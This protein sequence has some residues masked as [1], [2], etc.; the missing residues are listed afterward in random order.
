[1]LKGTHIVIGVTGGIAA[2]KI[3]LLVRD[4]KRS[5]ADVRVVMSESAA[6]FVTPMTLATVSG[7]DVVVGTFPAKEKGS[8]RGGTWHIDLGRW[9]GVMLI[10][11]ATANVIAKLANG[12]ADNA[13]ET[14]ALALRCPLIVAPSMDVDMWQ[15][16]STQ[17]NILALK[18]L[19]YRVLPPDEGEL[20]SGLTGPGRLPEIA[21]LIKALEE[22][23]AR[24]RDDL[25]GKRVLVT[26]GPT[27]EP[28]DPVRFIGNRSSGK[29]G[30][31]IANA[32]AQRGATV[33]LIAGNVEH[34]TPRNV[35]RIDVSSASDMYDAVMANRRK[36][37][38]IIMAAAVADYAPINPSS[39]K[40]KKKI[41][42]KNVGATRD[43]NAGATRMT[44]E[45]AETKDIL[46]ELGE[47]NAGSVLVGFALETHDGVRH[48]KEK[49]RAKKLDFIV[50]NNPL[51]K[52]AG[53]GTDTNIVT[54]IS[55][56]G[57]VERLSKMSKF[58][59]AH[60]LLDRAAARL[61]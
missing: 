40:I 21:V 42:D 61:K 11:P 27:Y 26:A 22:T 8:A 28:I 13:V 52:G 16:P 47:K 43:K 3:P 4:L 41:T 36:Q 7:N 29:M 15:H 30:F 39:K 32:A 38:L 34:R 48:A 44:L 53:F 51:E 24:T 2:Y 19:G 31:A 37:D 25:K 60:E 9:A 6:E 12:T 57:K 46:R 17:D 14:L 20:A 10:A 45:L 18:Q 55:R 33:T 49:L 1:M 50:L 35:R 56:S 5:G 23:V 59:V 54:I 58:D